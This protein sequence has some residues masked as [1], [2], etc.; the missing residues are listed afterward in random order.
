MQDL[1]ELSVRGKLQRFPSLHVQGVCAIVRGRFIKT[2]TIFDQFWLEADQVPGLD[3]VAENLRGRRRPPD[4][5]V[6]VQR[7][8]DIRPRYA[9]PHGWQNFAVLRLTSYEDWFQKQISAATRRNV[10]ASEKRGIVVRV[11]EFDDAYVAGISA[12]YNESPI[13]AGRRYW[14]YGKS[15]EAVRRE[16]GTYSDRSTFLGAFI[17]EDMVG[18]MKI[19]WDRQTAAIM[20]IVSKMSARDARPNNALMAEAVRQVCAR[21][22]E[23]LIYEK[24]DYGKKVGDSLTKFKEGNGFERM[25]VPC[26]SIPLTAKGRLAVAVG[27]DRNVMQLIPEAVAARLRAWRTKWFEARAAAR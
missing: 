20:Q 16:N 21:G 25:D 27:L 8:P 2:A 26:Y 17:G 13:R 11:C 14:H 7:V 18:Y 15:V 22:V 6:Y 1:L 4:L 9:Y 19:V 23:W 24:Y 5:F 3:K 12:I 10:R